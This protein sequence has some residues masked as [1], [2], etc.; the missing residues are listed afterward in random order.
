LRYNPLNINDIFIRE[1]E[2]ELEAALQIVSEYLEYANFD[3][4]TKLEELMY[5]AGMPIPTLVKSARKV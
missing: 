5:G 3:T 4:L 1:K 2:L